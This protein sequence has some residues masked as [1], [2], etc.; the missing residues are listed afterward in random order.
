M[1]AGVV[2]AR[3]PGKIVLW[4]EYAV[5]AGAPA[6][7][8]AVDRYATCTLE[9]GSGNAW[10]LTA[11][12][13]PAA[14]GTVS[15]ARLTGD[16]AAPAEGAIDA[17]LHQVLHAVPAESLPAGGRAHFDTAGFH[18]EGHK[19]GL[20]S[21]AALTVAVYGAVCRLLGLE[22][23]EETAHAI[24][25]AFQG[26][27]GSGIDVAAAWHGGTLRCRR[28]DAG[29]SPE[30]TPWPLPSELAMHTVWTGSAAST[31]AHLGRLQCWLN[32]GGGRELDE[33]TESARGVFHAADLLEALASYVD[34]LDALDRAAE[35]GIFSPPHRHLQRLAIAAGVVYK[36]CGAGGGDIGA[37]FATDAT[38]IE[39]FVDLARRAGFLP[40]ALETASHGLEVTG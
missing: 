35:L 20:G 36:P 19:L 32:R 12:G 26:G 1:S 27:S 21:S 8:M 3:A 23:G 17:I 10:S 14:A 2:R 37:A 15:R 30:A 18:H 22:A 11:A 4:G 9:P 31:G 6:L 39:Q 40:L 38:A 7:V 34:R 33:L 16:A 5:L 25:R 29:G 28:A 13:H 24:H